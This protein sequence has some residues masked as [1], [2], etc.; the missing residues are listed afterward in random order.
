MTATFT[1]TATTTD[2]KT[3]ILDTPAP[4]GAGR[5]RVTVEPV[6]EQHPLK[7]ME[8]LDQ[9]RQDQQDR[10][11]VPRTREEIDEAVREERAGWDD[12]P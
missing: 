4:V 9:L 12:R 1:T 8:F 7:L 6:T 3:L 10:G 2:G 5:V 11:H